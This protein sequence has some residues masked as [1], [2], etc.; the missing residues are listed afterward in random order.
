MKRLLAGFIFAAAS[1]VPA[2]VPAAA[3]AQV[4]IRIGPPPPVIERRPPPPAPARRRAAAAGRGD[5][6][7][8]VWV[9]GGWVLPPR[10][11]AV[12][13]PAHYRQTPGGWVFVPGH[14]R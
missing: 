6:G 13:V 3:D 1:L 7:R 8:Y 2:L 5:G 12:W 9:P 10:P 4:V 14:W 11:R